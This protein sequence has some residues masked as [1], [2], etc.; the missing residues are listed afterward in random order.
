[1]HPF[2]RRR[3]VLCLFSLVLAVCLLASPAFAQKKTASPKPT[4]SP[5]A[6]PSA[7]PA[8]VLPDIV[9][10]VNGDPIKRPDLERMTDL[11]L[12]S[13]GRSAAQ[14]SPVE[15]K[16]TYQTVLD[17][18]I[19]DRLIAAQAL[20]EPVPD[21]DV[22]KRFDELKA[23][24]PSE[25][26]FNKE[27]QKSGQ[28]V[29][30]VRQNLR[31]Q[32]A[33]QQWA[34]RQIADDVKVT[35]QEVEKFYM[36]GP[37]GKFDAPEMVRA[38]HIL[39]AVRRDA[40]PEY[41]VAAEKTA[42]DLIE[43]LKKGEKGEDVAKEKSDDPTAKQTGGDLDYFSRERIMPEFADVAFK[44]K[45]GEISA[46]VRTQFGYHII[47]VTDRKSAHT[48]TFD[49]AR[50]QITAYLKE[51]KRQAAVAKLVANLRDNAKIENFIA[52]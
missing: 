1:M 20:K 48:A 27:I 41:A 42:L 47:K 10:R 21:M 36:D 2:P 13:S 38:S 9:A 15:K 34:E 37:P 46:P 23:Q 52:P 31:N 30:R 4:T 8:Y 35:P 26:A 43:R 22:L 11:L 16:K 25:E 45:V 17:T 50:D 6:S 49:E 33:Q 28:T 19:T 24:S 14:L 7:A 18:M 29:D 40:A 39:V 51:Q 3:T 12:T 44:L 32:L 5:S